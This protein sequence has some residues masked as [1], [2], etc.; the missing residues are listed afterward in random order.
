MKYYGFWNIETGVT[1][2]RPFDEMNNADDPWYG[3]SDMWN[4]SGPWDTRADAEAAAD[5]GAD[6]LRQIVIR[7]AGTSPAEA[8]N[9]AVIGIGDPIPDGWFAKSEADT[10]AEAY[11]FID[12]QISW[13]RINGIG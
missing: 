1:D 9:Y 8:E 7:K 5:A 12:Q 4:G 6:S 2:V 13:C 11:R 10:L 3:K